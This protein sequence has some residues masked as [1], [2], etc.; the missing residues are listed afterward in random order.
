MEAPE[1]RAKKKKV[2]KHAL[3]VWFR[4]QATREDLSVS[5][6]GIYVWTEGEIARTSRHEVPTLSYQIITIAW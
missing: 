2:A 1:T 4:S 5:C 3:A 6:D